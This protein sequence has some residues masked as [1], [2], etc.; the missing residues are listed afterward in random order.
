MWKMYFVYRWY[1][2]SEIRPRNT[3]R[4][5]PSWLAFTKCVFWGNDVMMDWCIT[6]NAISKCLRSSTRQSGYLVILDGETNLGVSLL[7][8]KFWGHRG[9]LKLVRTPWIISFRFS[10]SM[11]HCGNLT[12]TLDAHSIMNALSRG[13]ML[14]EAWLMPT[15]ERARVV[16][17]HMIGG[18]TKLYRRH[19]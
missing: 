14:E 11:K 8:P 15:L 3:R 6:N 10:L 17:M 18:T 1:S 16:F 12:E 4:I 2:F 13:Y 19:G 9:A 7:H 5:Q